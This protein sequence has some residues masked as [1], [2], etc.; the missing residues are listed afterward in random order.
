[1]SFVITMRS[2]NSLEEFR[3][4]ATR[5]HKSDWRVTTTHRDTGLQHEYYIHQG[6]IYHV[7]FLSA[8][9]WTH[10]SEFVVG[11][12]VRRIAASERRAVLA[13]IQ[14][15]DQDTTKR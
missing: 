8:P 10:T 5:I 11:T 6:Q 12:K 15:K 9:P 3:V 7:Q 2:D 1:M 14:T 13:A 4:E